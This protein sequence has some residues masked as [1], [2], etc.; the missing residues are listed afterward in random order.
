MSKFKT[1]TVK[2]KEISISTK[3]NTK[4][5]QVPR[6][7]SGKDDNNLYSAAKGLFANK[8]NPRNLPP[9]PDPPEP[10]DSSIAKSK[11]SIDLACDNMAPN[12]P[13][14]GTLVCLLGQAMMEPVTELTIS[15]VQDFCKALSNV[16]AA[17][18]AYSITPTMHG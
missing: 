15:I 13:P 7:Q 6:E 14:K 17:K 5:I 10:S 12:L 2:T 9:E 18:H 1:P 16:L 3:W 11:D 8:S 4:P